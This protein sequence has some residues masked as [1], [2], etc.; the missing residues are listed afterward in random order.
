M[1][2]D[3]SF[4]G[5]GKPWPPPSERERLERYVYN[6]KLF[7]NDCDDKYREQS[8]RIERVI[9]DYQ[10]VVSYHLAL[11]YPKRVS[12]KTADLLLAEMGRG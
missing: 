3:L 9:G 8:K 11:N 1:L 4:L 7:A 10:E 6:R 2:T 5:P 12:M